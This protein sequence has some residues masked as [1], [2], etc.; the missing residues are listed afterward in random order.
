[1]I[2][3]R[4][5]QGVLASAL[6]LLAL[7]CGPVAAAPIRVACVGDSITEGAGLG[8]PSVESYPARLQRLLGTNYT[9]R[10]FGVS[11]RTLL[12]K[13]D[14]PYWK[15]P[16]FKQSH[17]FAPDVVI[18]KLGSNDAKPY[19]WKYGSEYVSDYEELIASYASLPSAPRIL[20]GT[21]APV[22]KKGAFDIDP[23]VVRTNIAVR[24]RELAMV[25]GRELIEF[26]DRMDGHGEWFPDTVHPN[27]RGTSVMAAIAFGAVTRTPAPEAA[28]E[29]DLQSAPA[30]RAWV[31]W[32]AEAADHVL[33]GTTAPKASNTVWLVVDGSFVNNGTHIRT[34]NSPG[35]LRLY[36]LWRP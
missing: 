24:V 35:S 3:V 11:G 8:N 21:P 26:H 4:S 29:L 17:D 36:R 28:P 32:S 25:P 30:G 7:A 22:F 16:A 33:L 14:F 19:N 27:A 6:W 31:S 15:E 2:P 23:G 18:I 20:L 10:N 13:G 12:K 34:T 9:V 1:V 5:L